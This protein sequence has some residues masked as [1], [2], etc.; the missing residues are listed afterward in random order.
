VCPNANAL[1]TCTAPRRTRVG[2][3]EV[4]EQV[5]EE[6]RHRVLERV[7]HELQP[8]G[9]EEGPT[10]RTQMSGMQENTQIRRKYVNSRG[11]CNCKRYNKHIGKL[12]EFKENTDF[13]AFSPAAPRKGLLPQPTGSKG[14]GNREYP[15]KNTLRNAT[16]YFILE[17]LKVLLFQ[18]NYVLSRAFNSDFRIWVMGVGRAARGRGRSRA[19]ARPRRG[20]GSAAAAP[21][22]PHRRDRSPSGRAEARLLS[23]I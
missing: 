5:L 6:N 20:P 22:R 16:F 3:L 21:A 9:A 14:T 18:G 2:G 13:P 11:I 17:V 10:P 4:R 1:H 23:R 15:V 12:S 19:P 8:R 7:V